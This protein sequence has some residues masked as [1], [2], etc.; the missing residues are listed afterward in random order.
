MSDDAKAIT[1]TAEKKSGGEWV[2]RFVE[3]AKGEIKGATPTSAAPYVAATGS[4]LRV[5]GESAVTGAL[6]GTTRAVFGHGAADAA[7]A[8][9]IGLSAIGSIGLAGVAPGIAGDVR[10]VGAAAAAVLSDRKAEGLIGAKRGA[11]PAKTT[12]KGATVHGEIEDDPILRAAERL[13]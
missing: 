9:T 7:A 13:G 10:Q 4:T 1:T 6:L 3:R 2:K 12:T 8:A 11:P 5:F